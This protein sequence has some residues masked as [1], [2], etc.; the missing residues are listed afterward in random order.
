MLRVPCKAEALRWCCIAAAVTLFVSTVSFCEQPKQSASIPESQQRTPAS[1]DDGKVQVSR[2]AVPPPR[3]V[4]Q[5]RFEPP[6]GQILFIA[7]QTKQG[8]EGLAT[9]FP[10]P[11]GVSFYT[12][13]Q[14]LWGTGLSDKTNPETRD[15]LVRLVGEQDLDYLVRK[16]PNSARHVGLS[17]DGGVL[18]K[19]AFGERVKVDGVEVDPR[20]NV[21]ELIDLLQ[22]LARELFLRIESDKDWPCNAYDP[23][24]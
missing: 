23:R 14:N 6:P 18:A 13:V 7:G 11:G 5:G 24:F 17:L 20:A 12:S 21:R 22:K 10:A 1:Q 19:L 2:P 4:G 16:F 8:L 3:V 9:N 15:R